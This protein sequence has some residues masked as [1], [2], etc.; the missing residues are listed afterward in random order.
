MRLDSDG[1]GTFSGFVSASGP[2]SQIR[3]NGNSVGC[4]IALTNTIVGANRRNWGIFTEENV[5]GDFVIKRSTIS[6]GSANTNVLSLSRDGAATF[7]SS[8]TANGGTFSNRVSVGNGLSTGYFSVTNATSGISASFSDNINNTLQ[9]FHSSAGARIDCNTNLIL[10][11]GATPTN[12]MTLTSGGNVG[13]GTT[14][15]Y[16]LDVAAGSNGSVFTP[17]ARITSS[18]GGAGGGT[19][20][21]INHTANSVSGLQILQASA[22]GGNYTG[23]T[24]TENSFMIFGTN[25]TER[26]RITSGGNVFFGKSTDDDSIVGMK[27]TQVGLMTITRDSNNTAIFRRNGNNGTI[28]TFDYAGTTV[29][30]ISTNTNSLPSDY[31]FKKDITNISLGLNLINKLRPV[32]YRHKIDNDNEPL[33][34]GIIAQELEQALLECGFENNSLLMLQHIPNEKEGESQY[35]VDY[36]KMIPILVKAMQEQQLQIEELKAKI[37]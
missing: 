18:T 22:A 37:K 29:G 3:V 20:L 12:V 26:M 9:I 6:G 25:A 35:W 23:I 30:S 24:N 33:S 32:N 13:I 19:I 16:V 8:V 28:M 36:T 15:T 11:T 2:K 34:N 14:P 27:I 10:A 31:N 1:G 4:G 5:E 17:A 21:Q 7:S